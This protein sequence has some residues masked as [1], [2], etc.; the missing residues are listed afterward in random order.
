MLR[1]PHS[2]FLPR[3][4][5]HLLSPFILPVIFVDAAK[6]R[7][8]GCSSP[9]QSAPLRRQVSRPAGGCPASGWKADGVRR[10][11]E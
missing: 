2:P 10:V 9:A 4:K 11:P 7:E 5:T 8:G 3:S 1:S 6:V